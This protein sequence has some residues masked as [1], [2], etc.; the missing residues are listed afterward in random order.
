MLT[1]RRGPAYEMFL[2]DSWQ[3]LGTQL[4]AISGAVIRSEGPGLLGQLALAAASGIQVPR[5]VVAT[6]PVR[7]RS[8]LPPGRLILK[9]LHCHFIEAAPG[10]LAG[11]F[12]ELL[13]S[14]AL[15]R[16]AGVP[17]PPVIVQQYIDH[18]LELRTYFVRGEVWHSRSAERAGRP[19]GK[20]RTAGR[21]AGRAAAAV[22]AA[23]VRL[24]DA[25][26][27]DYGAFD[28]LMSNG[29]PRFLE[30]SPTGDWRWIETRIGTAPVTMAVARMLRIS[31]LV[32]AGAARRSEPDRAD[33]VPLGRR[34]GFTGE[35]LTDYS[36]LPYINK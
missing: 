4:A 33:H 7:A 16:A 19:V 6:S 24:A 23:V 10:L 32:G 17:G 20:P 5:T 31:T 21:A 13:D 2:R 14:D 30:V 28:F 27:L 29:R 12:P 35:L 8:L 15:G 25:M 36:P 3:A 34:P 11:I 18:E 22:R 1:D 9:A 26:S